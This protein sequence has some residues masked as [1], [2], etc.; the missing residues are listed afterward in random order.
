MLATSQFL[1]P[2]QHRNFGAN[3]KALKI[4]MKSV[5]SIKKITKAMKMV[6]ASKM[7]GDLKRLDNGKHYGLNAVDMIFKSDT[8]MQR[9]TTEE[10]GDPKELLVPITSDKGM[11]GGVNSGI[12]RN[13][14][15]YVKEKKRSNL[16][17]FCLGGKGASAM[18]R[19]MP[20][21]LKIAVSEIKTPYNYP[22]VMALSEHIIQ[23]AEGSDKICIFYNE[24]KSAIATIIR[25]MELLP[26]KRFLETM[27][28]GKLYN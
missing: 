18:A 20:D 23:Q 14:R 3:E 5:N 21:L 7:A 6:A 1:I 17:I 8:Y 28:Y 26:R 9:R 27:K 4:R 25:K 11:C 15:D 2:T 10:K 22:T 13:I 12:F 19:P 24:F 16:Q